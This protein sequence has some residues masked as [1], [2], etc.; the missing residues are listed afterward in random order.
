MSVR[1]GSEVVEETGGAV[2]VAGQQEGG[3]RA[4]QK[5]LILFQFKKKSHAGVNGCA[6]T[7]TPTPPGHTHPQQC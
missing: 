4:P 6:P 5:S 7:P 3:G 1:A 2:D